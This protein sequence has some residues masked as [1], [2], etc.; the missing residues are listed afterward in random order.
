LTYDGGH[1]Y[2]SDRYAATHLGEVPAESL[3]A[4]GLGAEEEE[5]MDI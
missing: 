4:L 3:E 5:Q 1:F 2:F